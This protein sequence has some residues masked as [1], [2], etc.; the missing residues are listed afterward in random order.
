MQGEERT[1]HEAVGPSLQEPG[2][3]AAP[4]PDSPAAPTHWNLE[5]EASSPTA[6]ASA[7]RGGWVDESPATSP[8]PQPHKGWVGTS[9]ESSPTAVASARRGGRVDESPASSAVGASTQPMGWVAAASPPLSTLD[10]GSDVTTSPVRLLDS[11]PSPPSPRTPP[12]LLSPSPLQKEA[13]RFTPRG[14]VPR[15]RAE[16]LDTVV[17]APTTA[18]ARNT[19]R[20]ATTE[21]VP[22]FRAEDWDKVVFCAAGISPTPPSTSASAAPST[23]IRQLFRE[24]REDTVPVMGEQRL[25]PVMGRPPPLGSLTGMHLGSQLMAEVLQAAPPELQQPLS[26]YGGVLS[27]MANIYCLYV[28]AELGWLY[29]TGWGSVWG[30]AFRC[31]RCVLVMVGLPLLLPAVARFVLQVNVPHTRPSPHTTTVPKSRAICTRS[32][33]LGC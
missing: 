14:A 29:Q 27:E 1:L 19:E 4:A 32:S 5:S 20:D 25:V 22:R 31:L 9:E 33:W 11:A 15:F 21:I 16:D 24:E 28:F 13:F 8:T 7:R 26:R 12:P 10:S 23:G 2:G 6:V 18:A 3:S 30:V 17:S